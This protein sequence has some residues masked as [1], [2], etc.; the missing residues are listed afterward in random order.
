MPNAPPALF[1]VPTEQRQAA[2]WLAPEV[3]GGPVRVSSRELGVGA[4]VNVEGPAVYRVGRST[5]SFGG[6]VH[7]GATTELQE[8]PFGQRLAMTTTVR[9]TDA[10]GALPPGPARQHRADVIEAQDD[11]FGLYREGELSEFVQDPTA[12]DGFAAR[13]LGSDIEWSVQWNYDARLFEPDTR[14]TLYGAM[15]IDKQG[16]AGKAFDFGVY[17]AAKAAGVCGGSRNA[18]DLNDGEWT[19]TE[20]GTYV[21]GPEQYVWTAPCRNGDNVPWVYVDRF[22]FEKAE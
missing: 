20:F 13:Q 18:A 11:Q 12:S 10:A 6:G 4:E 9:L 5:T 19:T 1:L 2:E 8:V 16:E 7:L 21:P 14:Y 17:D 3:L 15:R 22:W